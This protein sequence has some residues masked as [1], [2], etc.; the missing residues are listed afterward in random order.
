[1]ISGDPSPDAITLWTRL[2]DVEGSGTVEPEVARDR[3]FRK[4]VAREL[5]K[6]S[7]AVGWSVKAMA[8]LDPHE[9]YWYRFSTRG[10][11]SQVGRFRTALPP[12]SRGSRCASPSFPARRLY[13]LLQRPQPA[14]PGGCGLRRQ[15]R[16]LHLRRG[17][18]PTGR[19]VR[20]LSGK[21]RSASR[22]RSTSTGPSTRSTAPRRRCDECT[23]S[24][25]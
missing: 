21:T 18:L 14:G 4:V 6:T 10:E 12:D 15:P 23:R 16:R 5:V 22:R 20:R 2:A 9:E 25:R 17:E 11:E 24:S 1:M 7:P 13:R 3:G 19:R 8:G